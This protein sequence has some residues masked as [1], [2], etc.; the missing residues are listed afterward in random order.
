[1]EKGTGV[2]PVEP[3]QGSGSSGGQQGVKHQPE[4][5]VEV[6]SHDWTFP[7]VVIHSLTSCR[8]AGV[9]EYLTS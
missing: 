7:P 8:K 5:W 9:E 2:E 3:L 4:C 6:G 1:M